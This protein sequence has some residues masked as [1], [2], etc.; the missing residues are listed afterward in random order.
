MRGTAETIIRRTVPVLRVVP[1]LKTRQTEVGNLVVLVAGSLNFIDHQLV[2]FS[3]Q[4]LVG[5]GPH[6]TADLIGERRAFMYVQQIKR[7]VIG[8]QFQSL[9]KISLPTSQRL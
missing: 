2:H 3:G 1:G 7:Q 8:P 9:N 6:S 4:I 5:P